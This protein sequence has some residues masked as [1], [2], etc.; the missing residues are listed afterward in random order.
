M[1]GSAR[2][3]SFPGTRHPRFR[4]AGISI[5]R[6][7]RRDCPAVIGIAGTQNIS[8][9]AGVATLTVTLSAA[10]TKP[11][12][13]DYRLEG[14]AT[15][16]VD[17]RLVN[18]TTNAAWPVGTITFKPG[19]VSKS[20]TIGVIND[21]IR[22]PDETI[23]V[24]L[25]KPQNVTLGTSR[26]ATV[27][28]VDDDAYTA[29][30]VGAARVNEGESS[31]FELVLSSPATKAE[32]F[33]VSTL[34]GSATQNLDYR[35][36]TQLALVLNRGEIRKSF[37]VQSLSDAS[38]EA[39]EFF[40][41]RATPA[42]ATFPKVAQKGVTIAGLGPAPLPQLTIG[43]AT[44]IEG[45]AGTT[46]VAVP[47]SLSFASPNP[48]SFSFRT[49][50]GT[51]RQGLDYQA[52]SGIVTI[53]VGETFTVITVNALGDLLQESNE[54]FT[55]TASAP[56]NATLQRAAGTVTIVENDTPFRI[57]VVFPDKSLSPSQQSAFRLAAVRWSQIITADLPDVVVNGRVID[58]LEITATGPFIDGPSGILGQAGP[59]ATRA[60]GSQL[61]Y[62]GIMEFDSADIASMEA[63]GTFKDVILHEMGHVLGIGSF[64]YR[65]NLVDITDATN[66][67][68]IGTNALREYRTLANAPT[69]TGVPVENTGG[70]GTYGSHW[71]ESVFRTELMTG[72]AEPAGVP[73]PI[74]RVTV[75]SLQ[76][77]GYTVTYAAADPYV[78][79]AIRSNAIVSRS[80][81][82]TTP[83]PRMAALM[84]Q[85]AHNLVAFIGLAGLERNA[86]PSPK[87]RAFATAVRA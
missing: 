57:D 2:Q 5:E 20:I 55:V 77:L 13:V 86:A 37:R 79:P 16:A 27:T 64:W 25:F 34:G 26:S 43:D 71:R 47:V 70:A 15:N 41:V 62:T 10:D 17:Y 76:D 45:D 1:A 33:Y 19:E 78:L 59:R 18:Q 6:L 24:S 36:L 44:V 14:T 68:Y 54:T 73:M 51:A 11:V 30:I 46:S 75:G 28:I 60:T 87:Q 21:T 31:V 52:A 3:G 50:D 49:A 40:F 8:E 48:V 58:D 12:S 84:S 72:Y 53:P 35:P 42:D 38:P 4:R 69:A 74:S 85:P 32:T 29:Q 61:P 67:L 56:Q 81:Q 9:G 7:E 63:D 82:T 39:D 83:R 65:K 22:D 23:K 66:P 80:N